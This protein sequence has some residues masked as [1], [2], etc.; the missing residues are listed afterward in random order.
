MTG[1]SLFK[2]G[3]DFICLIDLLA[4]EVTGDVIAIGLVYLITA[5]EATGD[6][7]QRISCSGHRR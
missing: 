2:A 5:I 4:I 3:N 1:I 7:D 6:V